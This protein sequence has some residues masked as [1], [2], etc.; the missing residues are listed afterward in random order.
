[1]GDLMRPISFAHL[2]TWAVEELR[3]E[4]SV[5]G[6]HASQFWRPSSTR[7]VSDPFGNALASP[8]GPAA[9]P[10]TQLAPNLVA[11]YVSGARFMELKTVQIM[12]GEQIRQAVAKPCIVAEDEGYNCEWST[13][14][15]VPEAFD[16]Y[17][18]AYVAISV[19]AKELGL[20]SISEVA[21]NI[22]VG[23]DLEGIRSEKIDAYIEGMKN[24]SDTP[25]FRECHDW[26]RTHLGDFSIS[27]RTTSM[28]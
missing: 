24:A 8:V 15:T 16:E 23:Y 28:R 22:S 26:V 11:A 13:E 12:D 27:A 6:V 1:M 17:V 20:G 4:S 9:G 3:S 5:F 18:K 25:I 19:L 7:T 2:M 14:L 21:F 10:Q